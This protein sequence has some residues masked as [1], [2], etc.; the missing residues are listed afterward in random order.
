MLCRLLRCL[1]C[2]DGLHSTAPGRPLVDRR[3]DVGRAAMQHF[4]VSSAAVCLTVC[5]CVRLLCCFLVF[6]VFG[7]KHFIDLCSFKRETG[8]FL[9]AVCGSPPFVHSILYK[10]IVVSSTIH[11]QAVSHEEQ[12]LG[13]IGVQCTSHVVACS[14]V[15]ELCLGLGGPASCLLTRKSPLHLLRRWILQHGRA[16]PSTRRS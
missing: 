2:G 5:V 9:S 11:I 16:P 14:Y 6:F 12:K 7:V 1:R 3:L 8:L 10:Y 15:I 13:Y 4:R